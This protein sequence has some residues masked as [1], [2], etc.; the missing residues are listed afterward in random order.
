[1]NIFTLQDDADTHLIVCVKETGILGTQYHLYG[2]INGVYQK[3]LP[4]L[5][6]DLQSPVLG[7][8][9]IDPA[10]IDAFDARVTPQSAETAIMPKYWFVSESGVYVSENL[11]NGDIKRLTD[12]WGADLVVEAVGKRESLADSVAVAAPG[13]VVSVLGAFQEPTVV[14]LPRMQAKNATLAM[15]MGDLGRMPELLKT[16]EAG[17]LDLTRIVTH[18]MDF[19]DVLQAYEVFDKKTEGAIKILLTT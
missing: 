8:V 18:K 9:F 11:Q 1:M 17:D 13:G 12:G 5:G 19:E 10:D 14:N 7:G 2:L 16:I 15:G 4:T 6:T 3:L